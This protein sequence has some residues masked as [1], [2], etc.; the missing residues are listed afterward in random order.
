MEQPAFQNPDPCDLIDS[1]V[2]LPIPANRALQ[3]EDP[4]YP[5]QPGDPAGDTTYEDEV[6][7][8]I[9]D[10]FWTDG[11]DKR[12]N[13]DRYAFL[14]FREIPELKEEA[15]FKKRECIRLLFQNDGIIASISNRNFFFPVEAVSAILEGLNAKD[16]G[17]CDLWDLAYEREISMMEL[18]KERI[19][20]HDALIDNAEIE[21]NYLNIRE[22]GRLVE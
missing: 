12:S 16:V 22:L 11:P 8:M 1:Y 5:N 21:A 2:S 9:N 10:R 6:M 19:D 20:V 14:V 15:R 7:A 18:T 4:N 17:Q 3:F 13:A